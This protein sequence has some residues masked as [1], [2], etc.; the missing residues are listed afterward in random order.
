MMLV[1][2]LLLLWG[3][4]RKVRTRCFALFDLTYF[5]SLRGT[6]TFAFYSTV[7]LLR[8][9]LCSCVVDPDSKSSHTNDQSSQVKS[10]TWCEACDV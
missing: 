9:Q 7:A 3:L 6:A 2:P 10:G 1:L 8:L 5:Y 4:R